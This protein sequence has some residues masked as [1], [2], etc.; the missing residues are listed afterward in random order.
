M[1]DPRFRDMNYGVVTET[2]EPGFLPAPLVTAARE[3]VGQ[4]VVVHI[5]S[6]FSVD[7]QLASVN[8]DETITVTDY[9]RRY[10]IALG[11]VAIIEGSKS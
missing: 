8:D 10:D 6:G 11:S 3:R 4:D 7:G 2:V 5:A 1:N 9:T